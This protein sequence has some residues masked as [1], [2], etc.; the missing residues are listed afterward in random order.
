MLDH[1]LAIA[2]PYLSHYGYAALFATIFM[3]GFGPPAPGQIML[4]GAAYLAALGDMHIASVLLVAWA[5]AVIGDNLGYAIGRYGGRH[6]ILRVGRRVGL[7]EAHLH[8]VESFFAHY[9]GEVVIAARFFEGLRQLNGI[10]AGVAGMSWPRFLAYNA[11]GAGLWVGVWGVGV[12]QFGRHMEQAL[13]MLQ[14][15]KPYAIAAGVFVL[16][17]LVVYL[18][19]RRRSR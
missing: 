10:V 18:F 16:V 4:I 1:Y 2:Q 8:R 11:I 9:G 6:L 13:R 12:Y 3:E 7:N 19:Q 14:I 17:F 5:A 15:I